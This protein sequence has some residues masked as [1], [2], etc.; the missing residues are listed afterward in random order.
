MPDVQEGGSAELLPLASGAEQ[1]L[2]IADPIRERFH[3]S[4][5]SSGLT[6]P[7][8]AALAQVLPVTEPL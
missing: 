6:T 8:P 4:P 7:T 1:R 5:V 2:L 3:R